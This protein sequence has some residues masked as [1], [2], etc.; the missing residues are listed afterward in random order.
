MAKQ[1][2]PQTRQDLKDNIRKTLREIPTTTRVLAWGFQVEKQNYVILKFVS[3]GINQVE[4]Y[5]STK[6]GRKTSEKAIV[7]IKSCKDH[8]V[9]FEL[10]LENLT[11]QIT[12]VETIEDAEIS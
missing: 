10:A 4:I 8:L 1:T 7:S 2:T 12:E 3:M 11:P 6:A 5:Q 9:A